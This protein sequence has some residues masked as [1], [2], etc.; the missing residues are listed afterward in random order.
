MREIKFR[1]KRLDNQ[2]WAYGSLNLIVSSG[3]CFINLSDTDFNNWWWQVD[4]TTVGQQI[5]LK[6]KNGV[7]IYEGD[8]FL[9]VDGNWGYGGDYDR[10]N[11]GYLRIVVPNI[12][13]II[14]GEIDFD[15]MWLQY[16]DCEVVGNIYENKD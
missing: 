10:N 3:N 1:G 6:D 13:D 11:D 16:Q 14:K 9:M 7:E 2:K 15:T 12:L 5:G 8:I 4:E